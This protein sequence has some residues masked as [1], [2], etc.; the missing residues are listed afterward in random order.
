MSNE[1][2][3]TGTIL[4][5]IVD[6]KR[7]ELIECKQARPLK[8]LETKARAAPPPRETVAALRTPGVSLIAEIKRASPS[9]GLL[10]PDLDP[11]EWAR[12]YVEG[13]AA[14]ISVLTDQ[15]FFQ[16]SL[17]DLCLVRQAVDVPVLRKDFVIEPYQVYEARAAGADLILL[18]VAI[19]CDQDLTTLYRL[20]RDL[21]MSALIEVHDER[22]LARALAVG[23]R[24]VG[25]N[26]RDLHTFTVDLGTTERLQDL[27]PDDVVLVSESG[28]H[29]RSDVERLA[30]LGADAMLV[31]ESLVKAQDVSAHVGE[32]VNAGKKET[33]T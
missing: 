18:I 11:A 16:G 21:G 9:K 33:R 15:R 3:R 12:T 22:E 25:I 23:P 30:A 5:K 6:H 26:N 24:I 31:G 29:T 14:A 4:D 8:A 32:L 2:P 20:V 7:R 28:V 10:H 19:L 27:V 1:T 13:G 17:D